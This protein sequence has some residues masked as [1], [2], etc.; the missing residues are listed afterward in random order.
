MTTR[1]S[2]N[3]DAHTDKLRFYPTLEDSIDEKGIR[4]IVVS[5]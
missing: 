4:I 2:P 5:L 3:F 1:P